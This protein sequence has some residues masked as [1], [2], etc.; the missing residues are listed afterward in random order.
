MTASPNLV[1]SPPSLVLDAAEPMPE[2]GASSVPSPT[3]PHGLAQLIQQRVWLHVRR[4]KAWFDSLP[5]QT[6]DYGTAEFFNDPDDPRLELRWQCEGEGRI[7][8][9]H[10]QRI[11]AQLAAPV[12][13]PL[14]MLA[15]SFALSRA[16]LD[17]IQA[18]VAQQLDPALGPV[19]AYLHGQTENA[20]VSG[21]LVKRLFGHPSNT[22]WHPTTNLGR[23]KLVHARETAPGDPTAL[24][25]DAML[26]P[27]LE[28]KLVLDPAIAR[29]VRRVSVHVPVKSWPLAEAV[30]AIELSAFHGL[31]VRL[32]VVGPPAT[33]AC[34]C[35]ARQK[36]PD[37]VW[38]N[39]WPNNSA[40]CP[41]DLPVRTSGPCVC[42]FRAARARTH[43]ASRMPSQPRSRA[44]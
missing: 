40:I 29:F 4:R 33:C 17:V 13:N 21:P 6:F 44:S 36:K 24:V 35:L 14:R 25:A 41:P 32:I 8:N 20:F 2:T 23:W 38:L 16:E 26:A 7:W 10:I 1:E 11:D 12:G 37:T 22:F 43:P 5:K 15:Q 39:A 18:C 30:H 19:F 31:A 28:G 27:W 34:A 42:A 3:A 9:A